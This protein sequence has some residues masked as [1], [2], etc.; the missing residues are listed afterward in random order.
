MGEK[1]FHYVPV[2][3]FRFSVVL[4]SLWVDGAH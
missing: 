4:R 1:L 3:Q 2:N